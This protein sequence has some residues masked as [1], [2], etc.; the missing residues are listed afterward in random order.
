MNIDKQERREKTGIRTENGHQNLS[1]L[2][3]N[4]TTFIVFGQC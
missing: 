2:L 3:R 4:L 1:Y